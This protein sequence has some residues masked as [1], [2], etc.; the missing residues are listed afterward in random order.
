[1]IIL[2]QTLIVMWYNYDLI[3]TGYVFLYIKKL[4]IFKNIKNFTN[5]HA[6]YKYNVIINLTK[7]TKLIFKKNRELN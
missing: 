5:L 6:L 3:M 4:K 7:I 1:M 2:R